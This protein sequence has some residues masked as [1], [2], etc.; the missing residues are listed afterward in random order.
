MT[1]TAIPTATAA[2]TILAIDL[3]KYKSVAC[4]YH[5]A[6]DQRFARVGTPRQELTRLLDNYRATMRIRR[7]I[8]AP[9]SPRP[10]YPIAAQAKSGG[11]GPGNSC[12][13]LRGCIITV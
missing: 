12:Y 1:T 2:D 11:A 10:A 6:D 4:I 7:P 5:A 9:N 8:P 3:G 13:R